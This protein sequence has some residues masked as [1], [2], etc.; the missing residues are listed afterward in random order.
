MDG[1]N[2]KYAQIKDGVVS[3][4]ITLTQEEI[5]AGIDRFKEGFDE[6]VDVSERDP[7]PG[8]SWLY[9]G[10][11][12]SEPAAV[13]PSQVSQLKLRRALRKAGLLATVQAAVTAAGEEMIEAWDYAEHFSRNDE[14]LNGMA[15]ALSLTSEQVDAL[16]I[17]ASAEV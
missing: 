7:M 14:L 6:L 13:V 2:M 10:S 4:V 11:E 12:F 1:E 5:D 16:F 15:A 3:N 8:V 9:N 17:A